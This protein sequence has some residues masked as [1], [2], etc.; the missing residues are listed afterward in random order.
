MLINDLSDSNAI[1]IVN[2]KIPCGVWFWR[3]IFR[4]RV[5]VSRI[6][7]I[8]FPTP[9]LLLNSKGDVFTQFLL[10][11]MGTSVRSKKPCNHVTTSFLDPPFFLLWIPARRQMTALHPMR[12]YIRISLVNSP[13]EFVWPTISLTYFPAQIFIALYLREP[14]AS[15]ALH[16]VSHN[17]SHHFSAPAL[18]GVPRSSSRRCV[19]N[20]SAAA[21]WATSCS[22]ADTRTHTHTLW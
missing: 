1:E 5:S 2:L 12:W 8:K 6:I 17:R 20:V 11:E 4:K 16:P 18:P 14:H 3:C 19:R 13:V 9:T 7:T 21:R 22:G 15:A 10:P